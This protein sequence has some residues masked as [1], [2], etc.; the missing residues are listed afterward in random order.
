MKLISI[1]FKNI[2]SLK[3]EHRVNF[4]KHP[5]NS[6]GIFAITGPTGS[7]KSTL[8]DVI[9]L[10]LY[11]QIPRLPKVS[12]SDIDE[13]G[14]IVTHFTDEAWAEVTYESKNERYRSKWEISKNRNDK[15]RDYNMSITNLA[16]NL[17]IEAKK[18]QIPSLN[19]EI[20]GLSY[21]QFVKSIILSQG[22]FARFLKAKKSERGK[23]LEDITGT[24]IYREIGKQA[25]QLNKEKKE[26]TDFL[27]ATLDAF[28]F[29]S[30]E[31]RASLQ[32]EIKDLT[33]TNNKTLKDIEKLEGQKTILETIKEVKKEEQAISEV[34]AQLEKEKE[35][36]KLDDLKLQ[37]HKQLEPYQ[38][39]LNELSGLKKD[40]RHESV[41]LPEYKEQIK[42]YKERKELTLKE[43]SSFIGQTVTAENINDKMI[44]FVKKVNELDND[45]KLLLGKG[46]DLRNDVRN[47]QGKQNLKVS[48][49]KDPKQALQLIAQRT[50][51]LNT[52]G[53]INT[54][55][56]NQEL[57]ELHR[58]I[59]V[60]NLIDKIYYENDIA[61][62]Q[63]STYN[64]QKSQL[65]LKIEKD[66]KI[67]TQLQKKINEATAEIK[68]QEQ[69]VSTAKT[70]A[71]R[72]DLKDGEP[73]PVC[74]ST[75]HPLSTHQALASFGQEQLKLEALKEQLK[76]E[77]KSFYECD[78]RKDVAISQQ[79]TIDQTTKDLEALISKAK[80][81]LKE[82]VSD[83]PWTKEYTF[84][85]SG[86]AR[87][88]LEKQIEHIE[89]LFSAKE[90]INDLQALKTL[91]EKIATTISH[92]N[93]IDSNR[94]RIY[95]GRDPHSEANE[96]ENRFKAAE[97]GFNNANKSA[98]DTAQRIELCTKKITDITK[99]LDKVI[100]SLGY[101]DTE[102]ALNYFLSVDEK[103]KIEEK[104]SQLRD[105]AVRLKT[106]KEKLASTQNKIEQSDIPSHPLEEI[107]NQIATLKN[108]LNENNIRLG[109]CQEKIESDNKLQ[110]QHKHKT[111][112]LQ[113]A[114]SANKRYQVL[115]E[116]IGDSTG[117]KFANYAQE[118]TLTRLI[119]FTNARLTGL[120]DRYLLDPNTNSED[121]FVIDQNQ[122]SSRRSVKT[123]SGGETFIISLALA[124]SL[125]DLA[126]QNVRLE[127]LFIDEGFGTLDP[128]TLDL[129]LSTL[130]KLQH[131]SGK[132][133]GVISHVASLKQRITTQIQVLKNAQGYS[134]L[135]LA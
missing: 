84:D 52:T 4:D 115:T 99:D 69:K 45:L 39:K 111:K 104:A 46:N 75:E 5:L 29:M 70:Q 61:R 117:N 125:S 79:V 58:R 32:S 124:L 119:S 86:D 54:T 2:H 72:D 98:K 65:F 82:L 93:Q 97:T 91:F 118:L 30:E 73:C 33:A 135:R 96:I 51:E 12:K 89:S 44:D 25:F 94:Q 112:E 42:K 53:E 87:L 130:E 74:G 7:G 21:D 80:I 88:K 11:N 24:H 50:K 1:A 122:G 132:V 55:V 81:Q 102:D 22:D 66:K 83:N 67:I 10:A 108:T 103:Q 85:G 100:L 127:C 14:S 105:A 8:L 34:Q 17:D 109:K 129:A 40:L 47:I 62:K 36:F 107:A 64:D 131:E 9:T 134:Q 57:S 26:K 90:E 56:L 23:L 120:T 95:K 41:H 106:R 77:E 133:I 43:F 128:E 121:L 113:A 27:R 60:T 101:K 16:T 20:I 116:L 110:A 49:G 6:A 3:G 114:L 28:E 31:E 48:F 19:T 15:W 18:S 63:I 68:I 38:L 13:I 71:L 123:L 92:Y 37:K 35:H 78:K 76:R 126:S 59:Q